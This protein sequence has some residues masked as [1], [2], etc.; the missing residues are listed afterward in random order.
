MGI[1]DD[2]DE[3]WLEGEITIISFKVEV[4]VK[5]GRGWKAGCLG[6]V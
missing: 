4:V 5:D 3:E 1:I 6:M 2:E